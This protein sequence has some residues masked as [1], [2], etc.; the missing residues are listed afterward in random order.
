MQD[1][2]RL[3][4]LLPTQ[5]MSSKDSPALQ[6]SSGY[7]RL[8]LPPRSFRVLAPDTSAQDGYSVYKRMP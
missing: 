6:V 5:P 7:L 1:T 3:K 8:T 2:T 4:D